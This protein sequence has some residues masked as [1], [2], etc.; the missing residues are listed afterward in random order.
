MTRSIAAFAAVGMLLAAQAQAAETALAR[1]NGVKGA[2]VVGQNGKFAPASAATTLRAG[3]RIVA[4]NGQ[5]SVAFAD[6]CQVTV[7]PQAM[8]TVG[9]ASPCALGPG[10]VTP[11]QGSSA[12]MS[13]TATFF[14]A[15]LGGAAFVWLIA[16]ES[17]DDVETVSP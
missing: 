17:D 1:V 4:K 16:E 10:L 12:Q 5:A 2:V 14:A 6:G 13:P 8:L 9:A 3:D 15:L 7:K 11:G